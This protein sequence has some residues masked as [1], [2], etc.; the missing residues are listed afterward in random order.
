MEKEKALEVIIQMSNCTLGFVP[1][2]PAEF[3]ELSALIYRK[4]QVDLSI[5]S[6]KRLWGYVKYNSFPSKSTLNTLA[7]FNGFKDWEAFLSEISTT[8]SGESSAFLK[9]SLINASSLTIGDKLTVKWGRGKECT[10]EYISYLRFKV[11]NAR[12]IKLQPSDTVTVHTICIGLP[13]FVSN[14]QREDAIIPLYIGAK[15]GGV[16]SINYQP[17]PPIAPL[18]ST[19]EN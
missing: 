10:L 15:N 4:T 9:D 8:D 3:N 19:Q 12:N 18:E 1:S 14:I 5:S 16:K 7:R 6:I 11:I 2:T 13:I 17:V